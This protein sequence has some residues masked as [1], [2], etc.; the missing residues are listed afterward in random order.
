MFRIFFSQSSFDDFLYKDIKFLIPRNHW[1]STSD[2]C[3]FPILQMLI[4]VFFFLL[5][6]LLWE[7][8][9]LCWDR[10]PVQGLNWWARG[11]RAGTLATKWGDPTVL[12]RQYICYDGW[13][14]C[15]EGACQDILTGINRQTTDSLER[16]RGCLCVWL[17]FMN[18]L[19]GL[20]LFS[21]TQNSRTTRRVSTL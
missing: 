6:A 20:Y 16:G 19:L 4:S 7:L 18:D 2:L 9:F 1:D 21:K 8:G 12:R 13:C 17:L 15:L 11:P 10:Y 3:L 5:S 14:K